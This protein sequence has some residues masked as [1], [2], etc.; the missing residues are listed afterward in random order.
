MRSSFRE[1]LEWE[2]LV[3]IAEQLIECFIKL[4]GLRAFHGDFGSGKVFLTSQNKVTIGDFAPI[5]P[6]GLQSKQQNPIEFYQIWFDEG[7]DGESNEI[8]KGCYLAPERL[9]FN[10]SESFEA[11]DLFS[12]GCVLMELFT[13]R[14][15]LQFKD[16]LKLSN[17]KDKEEYDRLLAGHINH[18]VTCTPIVDLVKRLCS[19]NPMERSLTFD[20]L[21]M[22]KSLADPKIRKWRNSINLYKTSESFYSKKFAIS[23]FP[24]E[25]HDHESLILLIL[26]RKSVV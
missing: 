25:I 20:D 21:E 1:S 19:F 17:A 13:S 8:G 10:P 4:H 6:F 3:W 7:L 9:K 16:T 22:I 24:K 2:D 26:D 14:G 11:A 15:F 18:G 5:K 23:Q 12:L